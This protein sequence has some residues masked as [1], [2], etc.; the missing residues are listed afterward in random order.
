MTNLGEKASQLNYN[1]VQ[2]GLR[3]EEVIQKVTNKQTTP[4]GEISGTVPA[5]VYLTVPSKIQESKNLMAF[6]RPVRV[7]KVYLKWEEQQIGED[8]Y[9]KGRSPGYFVHP[10]ALPKPL[11][12]VGGAETPPLQPP[13]TAHVTSP[14]IPGVQNIRTTELRSDSARVEW[15]VVRMPGLAYK[16][17]LNGVAQ[18][19]AVTEPMIEFL[20][21]K[22]GRRYKVEIRTQPYS[23][24]SRQAPSKKV[25]Y[26]F[27]TPLAVAAPLAQI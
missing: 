10:R 19:T 23:R 21:L 8:T 18:G 11:P 12:P 6:D 16:V 27:T 20:G 3:G 17:W 2:R 13:V 25:T 26:Y 24:M 5:L 4:E 22:P 14:V 7:P 9:A 15:D 1:V